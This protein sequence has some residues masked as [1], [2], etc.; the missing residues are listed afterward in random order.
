MIA[1]NRDVCILHMAV[2]SGV[3]HE[4]EDV[5]GARVK[6][7]Q[8]TAARRWKLGVARFANRIDDLAN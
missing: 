3:L 4:F 7:G 2:Y 5:A 8:K 1:N 6:N